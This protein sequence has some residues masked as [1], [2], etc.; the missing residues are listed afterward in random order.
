MKYA[1]NK[2]NTLT[3]ISNGT[4]S[5]PVSKVNDVLYISTTHKYPKRTNFLDAKINVF[6]HLPITYPIMQ[7]NIILPYKPKY[8]YPTILCREFGPPNAESG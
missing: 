5:A 8:K 6:L 2:S 3:R 1:K 4:E 7:E